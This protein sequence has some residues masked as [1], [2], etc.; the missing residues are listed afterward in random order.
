MRQS[1]ESPFSRSVAKRWIAKSAAKKCEGDARRSR[2]AKGRRLRG[3]DEARRARLMM[4]LE[5]CTCCVGG[6][7]AV[8]DGHDETAAVHHEGCTR[9]QDWQEIRDT[10][11]GAVIDFNGYGWQ[12]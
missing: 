11:Y 10:V 9:Q 5:T 8:E 3:W 1:C 4:R 6:C 12:V 7:Q 2:R